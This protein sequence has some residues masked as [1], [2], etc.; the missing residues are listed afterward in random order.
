M[1]PVKSHNAAGVPLVLLLVVSS[2]LLLL[3]TPPVAAAAAAVA[4]EDGEPNPSPCVTC[5]KSGCPILLQPGVPSLS[6]GAGYHYHR[7]EPGSNASPCVTC[8]KSGCPSFCSR[9]CRLCVD[10]QEDTITT[11]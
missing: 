4:A 9:G 8:L 11:M 10:L 7:E 2:L 5:L 1:A 6:A 3:A